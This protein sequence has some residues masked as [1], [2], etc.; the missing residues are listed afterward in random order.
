MFDAIT[1]LHVV[2]HLPPPEAAPRRLNQLIICTRIAIPRC[3]H[4]Y[5]NP[6]VLRCSAHS[7]RPPSPPMAYQ[8]AL[9]CLSSLISSKVRGVGTN[10]GDRFDIMLHYLQAC[11]GV[12]IFSLSLSSPSYASFR[13]SSFVD[14][15]TRRAN[16]Q[17]EGDSCSW[18]QRKGWFYFLFLLQLTAC[19]D[20]DDFCFCQGST[21]SF[22]ESILR[23]CGFRT[24]LFT[25]PHLIDVRERF[26]LEGWAFY[27]I[28]NNQN[29]LSR[30][31][32]LSFNSS[33][34]VFSI[35]LFFFNCTLSS[36]EISEDK[37]LE[38]FWWCWKKLEVCTYKPFWFLNEL[39]FSSSS[40]VDFHF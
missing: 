17:A 8:D 4:K 28:L 3:I 38:Y 40:I 20:F 21:C 9:N 11:L 24:G 6:I 19:C 16:F 5:L 2:T 32:S 33:F 14:I 35:P 29:L 12:A 27:E 1:N 22:A 13:C 18:D 39:Q 36:I 30:I 15:R 23:N 7:N 25:S 10:R 34:S 31:L 37:F 26:R